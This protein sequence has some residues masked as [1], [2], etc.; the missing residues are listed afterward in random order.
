MLHAR[1]LIFDSGL[2]YLLSQP[3]VCPQVGLNKDL[4]ALSIVLDCILKEVEEDK[5]VNSPVVT[6]GHLLLV[7][8]LN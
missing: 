3:P 2:V 5:L 1:A 6:D 4:A 8:P 7:L